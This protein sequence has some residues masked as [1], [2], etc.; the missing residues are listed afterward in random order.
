MRECF[1]KLTRRNR[2]CGFGVTRNTGVVFSTAK[3]SPSMIAD[4]AL[5]DFVDR[6]WFGKPFSKVSLIPRSEANLV[7]HERNRSL[8]SRPTW[9]QT[10]T[11][12]VTEWLSKILRLHQFYLQPKQSSWYLSKP[13]SS[14]Q[15]A[16]FPLKSRT[17]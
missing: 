13:H 8:G 4:K 1:S 6:L 15:S 2:V 3:I 11:G 7:H 12:W 16:L 5:I 14:S 10:T 9:V 17:Y